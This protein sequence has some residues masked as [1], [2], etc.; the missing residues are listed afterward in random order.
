MQR[1]DPD[2]AARARAR[3]LRKDWRCLADAAF[4]APGWR[5]RATRG[6]LM[7]FP[8]RR[9]ARPI[10]I[11]LTP[12]TRQRALENARADLRREGLDV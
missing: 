9:D 10:A 1:A 6:G 12:S 4:A 5:V 8:A 3:G 11:H 7:I 2:R